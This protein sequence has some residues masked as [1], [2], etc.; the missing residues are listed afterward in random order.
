MD[1]TRSLPA[2]TPPPSPAAHRPRFG[3]GA[4]I[5][6]DNLVR[7][8]KVADLEAG[9][10]P[11]PGERFGG[12]IVTNYLHRPLLATLI[13]ALD[14]R[15]VLI[16]ET[17]AAGNESYGRPSNP[18]FLL[19]PGELLDTVRGRLRVIAYEDLYVE[20]PRSAMVQRICAQR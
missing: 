7:I 1:V 20:S 11:Y 8:F 14:A 3:D 13:D 19:A 10:W 6:C 12:I 9:T 18:A 4:Q 5:A 2:P 17:F 16:Y 15:G